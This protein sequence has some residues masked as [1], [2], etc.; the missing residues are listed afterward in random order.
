[1]AEATQH[2][3]GWHPSPPDFRDHVYAIKPTVDLAALPA[4]VDLS[5]PPI[6]DQGAIG[7]CGAQSAAADIL[8]AA[9]SQQKLPT[10]PTP[11]RLFIYWI[12]R[13]VMGTVN[14]DSGVNNRALLKALAK[15]G[16]CDESLWEHDIRRFKVQPTQE[17]F[18]QAATR[19]IEKYESVPQDLLTMK[20]ALAAGDTFI[21]GFSVYSSL[22]TQAVQA[23]GIVPMPK[24]SDRFK[25]GHDVAIVGYDDST[26]RFKFK[27]SWGERW[28][29]NGFGE[30]PY[31]YATNPKLAGDFWTVT[32][33]ALPDPKPTPTPPDSSA[34]LTLGPF[35]IRTPSELGGLAS[36]HLKLT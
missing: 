20:A 15:Y 30:I 36:I 31:E 35:E 2:A 29:R 11:S 27:N 23:S 19:K 34:D 21:F 9:L 3:Y 17:A 13:Y 32:H 25:G 28:G 14:Q 26:G 18:K 16:W 24:N 12:A 5:S 22:E 33:A 6:F 8:H 1:M 10:A 4:A 7:S